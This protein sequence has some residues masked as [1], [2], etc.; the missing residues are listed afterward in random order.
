MT[1][2]IR[3]RLFKNEILKRR[4]RFSRA[5][6][7]GRGQRNTDNSR[8]VSSSN[9]IGHDL[10]PDNLLSIALFRRF[11]KTKKPYISLIHKA[12]YARLPDFSQASQAENGIMIAIQSNDALIDC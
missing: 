2:P 6:N 8:P 10:V 4:F 1:S 5:Q 7:Y 11:Q 3:Y 9:P 12:F